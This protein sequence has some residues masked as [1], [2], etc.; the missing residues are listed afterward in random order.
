MSPGPRGRHA[1]SSVSDGEG[2]VG[3][4]GE[5]GALFRQGAVPDGLDGAGEVHGIEGFG[6]DV[7]S[8]D[9]AVVLHLMGLDPNGLSFFFNGLDQKLVG[10]E[11]AQPI[12]QVIA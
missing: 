3:G 8:A 6:D 10:V 5:K 9:A 11:G 4:L 7:E 12:S 1:G 2:S